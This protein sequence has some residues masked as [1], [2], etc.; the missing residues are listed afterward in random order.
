MDETDQAE[1]QGKYTKKDCGMKWDKIQK[2]QQLK[3][4]NGKGKI[5]KTVQRR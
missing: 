1:D 2:Q 3:M 4:I 5:Y